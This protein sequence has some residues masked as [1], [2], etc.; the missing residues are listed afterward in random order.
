MISVQKK[1]ATWL[2]S[3][4]NRIKQCTTYLAMTIN[5][6]MNVHDKMCISVYMDT[7]AV[8]CT[9]LGTSK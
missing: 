5:L 3:P 2:L 9:V 7:H 1:D 8:F 6:L 4:N